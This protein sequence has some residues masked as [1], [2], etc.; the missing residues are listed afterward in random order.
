MDYCIPII[1]PYC[2][3]GA[4][5]QLLAV[6]QMVSIFLFVVFTGF[7]LYDDIKGKRFSL[8]RVSL[9]LYQLILFI[10]VLFL[11]VRIHGL[12]Y[13]DAVDLFFKLIVVFILL[14]DFLFSVYIKKRSNHN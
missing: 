3:N 12:D 2:S 14:I 11:I 1:W 8:F 13:L 5:T 10:I 7:H 9:Y 4:I 6:P